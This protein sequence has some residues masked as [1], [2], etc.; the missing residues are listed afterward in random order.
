MCAIVGFVAAYLVSGVVAV[1]GL[2]TR[3]LSLRSHIAFEPFIVVGALVALVV[4]FTV[5]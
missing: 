3:Q 5:V 1:V 4:R 2:A